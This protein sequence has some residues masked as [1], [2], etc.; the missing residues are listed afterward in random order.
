[1][2]TNYYLL[3]VLALGLPLAL[4]S[5][6][7]SDEAETTTPNVTPSAVKT[8]FTLSVGLP[9]GNNSGAKTRMSD[10]TAQAQTTPTFRGMDNMTLIPFAVKTAG[11]AVSSSDTPLGS[12][13]NLPNAV[14]NSVTTSQLSSTAN[15]KVYTDVSVPMNTNAF[16]FYGKAIDI[17]AG[18]DASTVTEKFQYGTVTTAGLNNRSA[19]SEISFTPAQIA[20]SPTLTKGNAI[21]TY[22]TNIA[23]ADGW[24]AVTADATGAGKALADLYSEFTEFSAGSS[25]SVQ[26][27][28]QDLY[29]SLESIKSSQ[30]EANQEVITAI[31]SAITNTTYVSSTTGG[32]LTFTDAISGYPEDNN[33]PDGAAT[34]TW[35]SSSKAFTVSQNSTYTKDGVLVSAFSNYVYPINLWYRANTP[36]KTSDNALTSEYTSSDNWTT[37]LTKYEG[38]NGTVTASTRSI[39]LKN[40]IQYAVARLDTKVTLAGTLYDHAGAVVIPASDGFPITGILVGGQRQVDWQFEPVT[41]SGTTQYTVYDKNMNGTLYASS[42]SS[43]YNHTL[44]LESAENQ[45]VN[46]VVELENNTGKA[47]YGY[48]GEVIPAGSKFYMVAQLDPSKGSSSSSS[49]GVNSKKVFQQDFTT[50]ANLTIGENSG[51]NHDSGLGAAYNVIPDLRTPALSIGLSVDL[52]WLSGLTFDITM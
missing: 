26:L 51:T 3:G 16:L 4:T 48:N 49:T 9:K 50:I 5:C 35:N 15:A 38:D 41:T 7:S 17:D 22:L 13:I 47:F 8:S 10:A 43:T 18:T 30:T 45:A 20:A 44:L 42:S 39:A 1:M 40:Q 25:K 24:S 21:A 27:A 29:T 2:K 31:E 28:V 46:M 6:S 19:L 36:I 23:T 12:N 37:I 52:T 34:V 14:A 32:T 11:S 33:L